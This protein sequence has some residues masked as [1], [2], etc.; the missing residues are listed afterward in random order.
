MADVKRAQARAQET[1]AHSRSSKVSGHSRDQR[2]EM[3]AKDRQDNLTNT[4]APAPLSDTLPVCC[5]A[6]EVEV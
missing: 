1:L 6:V 4:L 5:I 2:K 3:P